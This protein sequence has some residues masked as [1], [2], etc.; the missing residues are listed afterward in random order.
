MHIVMGVTGNVGSVVAE[1][2]LGRGEKVT[3]VTRRPQDADSWREKGASVAEADVEDVSSLRAAFRRGRR[4][5]VL[6]PPADPSGDTDATLVV[7][8]SLVGYSIYMRRLRDLGASRA[9]MYAFVSPVIA[10]LLGAAILGEE[11]TLAGVL[12]MSILLFSAWLAMSGPE[13]AE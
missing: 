5:F 8:G 6:N 4:A 13:A 12:G 10:V 1:E 9:G 2:L 3:V 11:I 7:F